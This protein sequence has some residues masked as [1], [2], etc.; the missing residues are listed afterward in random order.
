MQGASLVDACHDL[1]VCAVEAVH[2]D[3]TRLRLHV[4]VVRVCGVQIVFK[5]SQPVQMLDLR[6]TGRKKEEIN[7]NHK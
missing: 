2:P 4:S 3:H 6:D 7:D 5:H 1:V